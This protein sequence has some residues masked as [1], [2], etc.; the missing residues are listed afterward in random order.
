MRCWLCQRYIVSMCEV[1]FKPVTVIKAVDAL[2][3]LVKHIYAELFNW[4]MTVVDKALKSIGT[5]QRFI[6]VLDI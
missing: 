1:I 2:D 3:A 6:G 4:I 5:S